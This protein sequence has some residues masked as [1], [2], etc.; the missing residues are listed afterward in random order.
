MQG[1][2]HIVGMGQYHHQACAWHATKLRYGIPG[3][4]PKPSIIHYSKCIS[5]KEILQEVGKG[6]K[7]I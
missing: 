2:W 1:L 6:L 5:N 7:G 3:I 4:A